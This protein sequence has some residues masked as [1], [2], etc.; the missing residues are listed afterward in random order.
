MNVQESAVQSIHAKISGGERR[1]LY[2]YD[3]GRDPL[4]SKDRHTF[5][6]REY[7]TLRSLRDTGLVAE[8]K[9]PFLWS[10]D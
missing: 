3:L 4:S 2:L 1:T 10:D 5:Y 9:D 6:L 8:V 7:Q